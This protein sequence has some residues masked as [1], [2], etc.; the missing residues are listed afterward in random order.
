MSVIDHIALDE[1]ARAILT[2]NDR[3]GYTVPT[4]GLYPYQWNW[5]SAFAAWGFATFDVDRAWTEVETLFSGQWPSGMVPHILFHRPDPG[6]FPGP[7]VW[8]TE[9]IG[10]IPSSGVSQPPVAATLIRT[11]YE[12]DPDMGRKRLAALFPKIKAWHRWFMDWRSENGQ[13]FITHPW[14]A[15][16][17]NAPD[18]DCAMADITPSGVGPYTRRDTSH[19]DPSMRPTKEDYDRYIWLVQRGKRLNWD[20][21]RMA[22]DPPFR[23]ADPTMTFILLRANRD[24]AA[25]AD[26]LGEPRDDIDGWT[27]TLGR[28]A[29]RLENP[30]TGNFDA[31]N[32]LTG[33]HTGTLSNAAYL[34]WYGGIH[35]PR[36][37]AALEAT[38][39][40]VTHPV[41]SHD[42]AAEDFDP[43]RYW[44][45][46]TWAILNT[47]IGRGLA[48]MGHSDASERVRLATRRLIANHGFAEYFNPLTGAPAGGG[49]FTWTAAV[50]LAWASPSAGDI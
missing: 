16:R 17:D 24:L 33:R 49:T 7:D 35:S 5:D 25:L 26:A 50:W 41:P 34:C 31:V 44:R 29:L 22:E 47:M 8:G 46:P 4:A 23:V 3:G 27:K 40:N 11:I 10:P 37:L 48:D 43:K 28:G 21:A 1:Q 39:E 2:G 38:F 14:E 20:E 13:I 32:L 42:A 30:E 45:G 6:Y 15:G 19:V 12:A 18:W 36:M 9:G